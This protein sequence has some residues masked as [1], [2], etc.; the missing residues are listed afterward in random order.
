[1]VCP[2][3]AGPIRTKT[4]CSFAHSEIISHRSAKVQKV[5]HILCHYFLYNSV[6]CTFRRARR[7]TGSECFGHDD[8]WWQVSSSSSSVPNQTCHNQQ[9]VELHHREAQCHHS[10]HIR[11]SSPHEAFLSLALCS[12][13]GRNMATVIF[14]V[15]GKVII[16]CGGQ[17]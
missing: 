4:Q 8:S 15:F 17:L 9:G 6:K 14:I 16:S 13:Y 11:L 5:T 10:S 2:F 3:L 7:Q 1:M 12:R